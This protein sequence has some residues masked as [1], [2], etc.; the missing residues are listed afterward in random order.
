MLTKGSCWN[1]GQP[2][3]FHHTVIIIIILFI[4][5][6]CPPPP[7][8]RSSS[9]LQRSCHSLPVGSW[10]K[11]LYNLPALSKVAEQCCQAADLIFFIKSTSSF[12]FAVCW[13][14]CKLQ[15]LNDFAPFV[16]HWSIICVWVLFRHTVS[17]QFIRINWA[18]QNYPPQIPKVIL[19]LDSLSFHLGNLYFLTPSE[20]LAWV[21]ST[22]NSDHHWLFAVLHLFWLGL[23][24]F[25]PPFGVKQSYQALCL[26]E[27]G[28]A[29]Q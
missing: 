17:Q 11:E 28:A 26:V 6:H 3:S 14:R 9:L 24:Y 13:G 25:L 15:L 16:A 23:L 27:R 5:C 4:N 2:L 7:Y 18:F 10:Q 29:N 8:H 12:D 19:V 22:S 20:P 1:L 21:P